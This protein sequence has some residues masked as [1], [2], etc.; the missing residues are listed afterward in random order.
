MVSWLGSRTFN[1]NDLSSKAEGPFG[2]SDADAL[3]EY[4]MIKRARTYNEERGL[5]NNLDVDEGGRELLEIVAE[6]RSFYHWIPSKSKDKY[7]K[8]RESNVREDGGTRAGSPIE[9]IP[10]SRQA[11]GDSITMSSKGRTIKRRGEGF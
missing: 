9:S 7:G 1:R 2:L 4:E 5:G 11:T 3:A 10:M 8:V 6:P